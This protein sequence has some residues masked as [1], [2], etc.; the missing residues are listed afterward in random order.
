MDGSPPIRL[1][2]GQAEDLSPDGAWALATRFW[3][4]PPEQVLLPTGAGQPRTLPST[5]LENIATSEFLPDGKRL[6]VVGNEREHGL[7]AYVRDLDGGPLR[8]VTPEGMVVRQGIVSPDGR[9]VVGWIRGSAGANLYPLEGGEVRA[10]PARLPGEAIL[11]W[12]RDGRAVYVAT[13]GIFLGDIHR[14]DIA[15]GARTVWARLGGPPDPAGAGQGLV[16]LG[17]DDHTYAYA[18]TRYL[19]ELFLARGMR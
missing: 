18:Y 16:I 9:W 14:V 13:P 11:A 17:W 8:P 15:T 3:T 19:S 12:S 10:I 1:G 7:R 4:T 6:I 5:D 2:E